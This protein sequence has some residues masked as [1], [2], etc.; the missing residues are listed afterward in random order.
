MILYVSRVVTLLGA[1][2]LFVSSDVKR[3]NISR[4]SV[5]ID[6]WIFIGSKSGVE[7]A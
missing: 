7:D 2:I 3:Q 1:R 5:C 6:G 4:I